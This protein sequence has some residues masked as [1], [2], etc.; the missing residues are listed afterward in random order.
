M[1]TPFASTES[2]E[3]RRRGEVAIP[4]KG[5]FVAI[6]KCDVLCCERVAAIS[7]LAC[8]AISFFFA[9]SVNQPLTATRARVMRETSIVSMSNFGAKFHWPSVQFLWK[10]GQV[11]GIPAFRQFR[12]SA[13]IRHMDYLRDDR[14][15]ETTAITSYKPTSRYLSHV[16]I[17][18][19]SGLPTMH[20]Y[21]RW[22]WSL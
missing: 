20:Q 7:N 10:W 6:R 11:Y 15:P 17:W 19:T 21:E 4:G 1:A 5:I 22:R 2:R 3:T 8:V 16:P 14:Q 18:I 9:C 12:I 13:M